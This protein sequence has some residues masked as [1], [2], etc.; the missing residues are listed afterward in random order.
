M[1][2]AWTLLSP[3][4]L[5]EVLQ[6]VRLSRASD[7]DDD[8]SRDCR[9]LARGTGVWRTRGSQI[10][11][12]HRANVIVRPQTARTAAQSDAAKRDHYE[13][14]CSCSHVNKSLSSRPLAREAPP[15]LTKSDFTSALPAH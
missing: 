4:R 3:R 12:A 6:H 9:G 8:G 15:H 5:S 10:I 11:A 14:L 2:F 13:A 1:A 7:L